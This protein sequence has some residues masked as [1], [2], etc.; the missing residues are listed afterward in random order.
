MVT[1]ERCEL[2]PSWELAPS[3]GGVTVAPGAVSVRILFGAAHRAPA[4]EQRAQA[5]QPVLGLHEDEQGPPCPL[6]LRPSWGQALPHMAV[7][8]PRMHW[9]L[10][11]AR[12][13]WPWACLLGLTPSRRAAWA[14][15][16]GAAPQASLLRLPP[17]PHYLTG[18]WAQLMT[19]CQGGIELSETG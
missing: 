10:S 4:F 19:L 17:T 11:S 15:T 9:G 6:P 8:K 2:W 14:H 3:G 12:R 13:A 1:S 5:V 7:P 18:S 16:E